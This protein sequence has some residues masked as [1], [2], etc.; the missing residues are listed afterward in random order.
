[1]P[2]SE[3]PLLR[4]LNDRQAKAVVTTEGF[5]RV[6]A[7]AGS[8]KTKTLSSRYAYIVQELGI[9]S[10]NVLCVTFTN[11]AAKEMRK[12]ISYLIGSDNDFGYIATYHGFCVKILRQDIGRLGF[13][14]NFGIA[15]TEDQKVILREAYRKLNYSSKDLSFKEA[16]DYIGK[17]KAES[18]Y[19]TLFFFEGQYEKGSILDEVFHE[20]LR[21]QA[22]TF[23]L[24]FNDLIVFALHLLKEYSLVLEKWSSRLQY[25][26]VDEFQD[27]SNRQFELIDLLSRRHKNLFVVGDPDQTIYSWRGA[28]PE[29]LVDFDSVFENVNTV[30]M[31][32]NYRSTPSILN[33]SNAL[34]KQNSLRVEKELFTERED[35]PA[36]LYYHAESEV[37][38]AKWVLDKIQTAIGE[39]GYAYS[40]IVLL[41]RA[42]YLSRVFEQAFVKSSVPYKVYGGLR[43]FERKEI[44]DVLAYLRMLTTQD[45]ISF[46][47]SI[48]YPK[49]GLGKKFISE[50]QDFADSKSETLYQCLTKN[51]D[52]TEFNRAGAKD[53]IKTI[54]QLIALKAKGI[55]L[56]DLVQETLRIT[57][58]LDDLRND[59]DNERLDNLQEFQDSI[60]QLEKEELEVGVEEYLQ[61]VSLYTDVDRKVDGDNSVT[62]MTIHSAKGLEFPLVFIV[63]F[64]DGVIP[65]FRSLN[66]RSR[67]ALEEERR[68]SYVAMTRAENALF[69]SDHEGFNMRSGLENC[70]SRFL[71]EI[72]KDALTPDGEFDFENLRK[73]QPNSRRATTPKKKLALF[74]GDIV[75]HPMFGQ[76]VVQKVIS[77]EG[78]IKIHFFSLNDERLIQDDFEFLEFVERENQ[79]GEP[80]SKYYS[81]IESRGVSN[82][83]ATSLTKTESKK[84][85][86][87]AET[88]D[89]GTRKELKIKVQ[90]IRLNNKS[91]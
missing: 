49:R 66:Q 21:I 59:G 83:D 76:G 47:R 5:V 6:I 9:S 36:V 16:S 37:F 71:F 28:K 32:R 50:L 56:S 64:I 65:D 87:N 15:D 58:I 67:L 68:L 27:S 43:F 84:E 1:M 12:R 46:L 23:L 8:G 41:Y 57:G 70:P 79:L 80:V 55:S 26:M 72:P 19:I 60:V 24:D 81:E 10:S 30:V 91:K 69:I 53:F 82:E 90:T 17:M 52:R 51:L 34:I 4:G 35:G 75:A 33:I 25:I 3:S 89:K 61:E 11:K 29:L 7:G 48:N 78:K 14:K 42:H 22:K 31:D 77:S 62:L 38:E 45:D 20:Y 74:V 44:K 2:S 73:E 13:P 39:G 86:N 54:K 18:D 40:D 88:L 63:G 85:K